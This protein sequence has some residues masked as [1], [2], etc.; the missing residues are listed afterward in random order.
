MP[1]QS[2]GE[3][4][5][6]NA[7]GGGN[8]ATTHRSIANEYGDSSPHSLSEFNR[9][10]TLVPDLG[11][12]ND[13]IPTT[14]SNIKMS[15]FRGG[16]AGSLENFPGMTGGPNFVT[17]PSFSMR[18]S[19]YSGQA[20]ITVGVFS[21]ANF[22]L[23]QNN[24]RIEVLFNSASY[25]GSFSPSTNYI[26]YGKEL[27][28]GSDCTWSVMC[29]IPSGNSTIDSFQFGNGASATGPTLNY[30]QWYTLNSGTTDGV[31]SSSYRR[32]WNWTAT[33]NY[34]NPSGPFSDNARAG[35]GGVFADPDSV[36]FKYKCEKGGRTI[37]VGPGT[38]YPV[39]MIAQRGVYGPL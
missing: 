28:I 21:T 33:A 31:A 14:S 16:D 24:R 36:R 1:L 12:A 39:E 11:S 17:H 26:Y 34:N 35:F 4:S 5:L 30:N 37:T 8:V 29:E 18:L 20:G 19:H 27:D 10:G 23:D 32:V 2:S 3:I 22:E 25:A 13:N 7:S 9:G 15:Q 6:G 38:S